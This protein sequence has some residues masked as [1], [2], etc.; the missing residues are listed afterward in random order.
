MSRRAR[1]ASTLG[2]VIEHYLALKEAL[3]RRYAIERAVLQSLDAFLAGSH[4]ERAD[5]IAETFAGWCSTLQH[6]TTGVR[7]NRMRI[8]RALCLYRRRTEPDCFV[9]DPGLF[10][11]PHQPGRPYIFTEAEIGRLLHATR[12]L[13]RTTRSPLRPE[14]F[15]LAIVLLYT[16]GLRRGELLRMTAGDYDPHEHTL[17]VRASKFHKSRYLPLSS[18]GVLE[19][20]SYLRAR[21]ARHLPTSAETPLLWNGYAGGRGYTAVGLG[22]G[23]RIVLKVSDIRTPQ[24]R[25]PRLHD[26]RHTFA[27]HALVR[28]Y[29]AGADVQAKLPL[30]ATYLGHVSVVSTQYYLHFIEPLT[31]LAS[32]RFAQHYAGLVTPLAEHPGG[33]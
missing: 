12:T 25:H 31:S 9:P 26:F 2:G 23:L 14:I 20:E 24:G 8:A 6:L 19:V 7:R 17:L 10:P 32:T 5:L 3:G 16:T 1:F 13:E 29:R 28:W 27:V 33:D 21:R 15:H 30:L 4:A 11:A 22:H 18:D